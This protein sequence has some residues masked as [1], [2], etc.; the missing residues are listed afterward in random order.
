MR[1]QAQ[2]NIGKAQQKQKQYHDKGIKPEKFNIGDK[3]LLYESAKAGVHGYKF[4]IKWT[5]PYYIHD[6]SA[7]GAYKLRTMD[8]KI[9]RRTINTDRLKRYFE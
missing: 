2:Q 9:L 5:G 1:V 3:V 6:N 7:P 4:R 8:N